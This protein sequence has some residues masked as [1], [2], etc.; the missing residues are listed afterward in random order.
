MGACAVATAWTKA[1]SLGDTLA[2][3][4]AYITDE[5]IDLVSLD[6]L[7]SSQAISKIRFRAPTA[8]QSPAQMEALEDTWH[9]VER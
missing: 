5:R 8:T 6:L 4:R 1:L 7:F 9:G 3:L 2:I